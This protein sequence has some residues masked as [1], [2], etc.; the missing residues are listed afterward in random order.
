MNA[1]GRFGL[2]IPEINSSLDR[3]FVEG[4]YSQAERLGYDLVVYTGV[5]NSMRGVR[6]DAYIAGLENIYTLICL[7]KLD[8]IIFAYE[9][10]HTQEVI[11]KIAG[12]IS[13]T[14]T[15]CLVL[16]GECPKAQTMEA[17]EYNSMYRITRHM[18]DEHGC[19][20][21][22]C[23]AGVPHHKSSEKRLRGFK[24]ACTDCGITV[25]ESVIFYGY[26]WKEVPSQLGYDIANGKVECPDAIVCCSDV[27]AAVLVES[28]KQ[29]GIRVPEDVRV[30]GFDGGWDSIMCQPTV[31]T[32]TGRDKQFGADAVCR[33][34]AMTCGTMPI[35]EQKNTQNE[36]WRFDYVGTDKNGS[37]YKI[38]NMGTGRQVTPMGSKF[39][40]KG[41]T[42]K[43]CNWRPS[44][45][46]T[47]KA[48]SAA[49]AKSYCEKY[50]GPQNSASNMTYA[51]LAKAGYPSAGYTVAPSVKMDE[52]P[53][54]TNAATTTATTTV[55]TTT[56]ATP[57]A[58]GRLVK[59]LVPENGVAWSV[60]QGVTA[61][62]KVF[63]DRD[64]TYF[65]IPEMFKGV[66]LI[67]TN[68]DGKFIDGKQA[69]FIA[70]KNMT[71]Y[72][73]IDERVENIPDWLADWQKTSIRMTV[74]ND[75][76]FEVYS[77]CVREGETVILGTYSSQQCRRI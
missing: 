3:D 66:E 31:T 34:Y 63:T 68:C 65:S 45:N 77:R 38:T 42:A 23:L 4:A 40:L 10:F 30:T 32:I 57:P 49:D 1:K 54:Q 60:K 51:S 56:T 20:K 14:D 52:Q 35:S 11:D 2:V 8:G 75:V 6:Y 15:S 21:L 19:R 22:Y 71:V 59:S 24:D 29:K 46:Y 41:K 69:Q 44:S 70:E 73:A 39:S 72:V 47:Y 27:M 58:D 17:D 62:D 64:F 76:V 5:L 13:Q 37:F 28:L 43:D 36:S 50:S 61:G 12:Y 33:L 9:R 74:S 25:N 67:Q 53:V 16:G 18:T 26:F 7:H 48:K 55:T